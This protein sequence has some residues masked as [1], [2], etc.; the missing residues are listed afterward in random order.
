MIRI[1]VEQG[2][3]EW[4]AMRLGIPTASAF[5]RVMTAKTRKLA[6]AAD[7]YACA[8]IAEQILGQ[9]FEGA[10]SGFMQRGKEVESQA[11]A[12]YEMQRDITTEP[13]GFVLRHDRRVGCSPDRFVGNNGLLEIKVPSAA[14]HINYLLSENPFNDDYTVQVQGQ[15]WLTGRQWCD[16]LSYHELMPAAIVR[17]GRNEEF[18]RDLERVMDQFLLMM[19]GFKTRLQRRGLLPDHVEMPM[20][21]VA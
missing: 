19:D 21:I 10:S 20:R 12:F 14:N 3:L 5:D 11:V 15:L 18:I 6:A 16:T 1:D 9:P 13:G 7:G 4:L 17:E 8:L 2:S